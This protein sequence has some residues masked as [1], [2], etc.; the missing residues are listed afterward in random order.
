MLKAQNG[1]ELGL[2][3]FLCHLMRFDH[4][5]LC[6]KLDHFSMTLLREK[7]VN[8]ILYLM[9]QRDSFE[10]WMTL[11]I[12]TNNYY[13]GCSALYVMGAADKIDREDVIQYVKACQGENGGF[14][15]NIGMDPHIHATLSAIQVLILIDALDTVDTTKTVEWIAS[16]QNE[17]GSFNGDQW[18]EVDTRFAYCSLC[19]LSLLNKLDVVDVKKC[20]EWLKKCQNFDGGF[21]CV[22]GCESHAGQVLTSLGAL[23]I[24]GALNE[25]DKESLGFWLS[26][27]QDPSGGF[28]G[29][30]EKLPDVC[31]S[32]WVGAS[33]A[34]IGKE[35]WVDA[36][37][38]EAFVLSAQ[39]EE[40]GGIADRPGD[41][42]DPFHTFLGTA[43]L[44]L[45]DRLGIPKMDPVY[46][47][48]V[49]VVQRHFAKYNK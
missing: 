11:P 14:G 19:A 2:M 45:F 15:G 1:N 48:P 44:S 34:I 28:N 25:I 35:K 8:F 3:L 24:A 27:R 16:L 9:K 7:H 22:D 36:D 20:V 10:Y 21:G 31:Y 30:P 26:E 29:R 41:M 40:L 13:W 12:R 23:A 17:D 46:A 32:W 6:G 5:P 39:D 47:L 49:E 18:G 33:I 4:F 37:K 42:A 43:G 38:L